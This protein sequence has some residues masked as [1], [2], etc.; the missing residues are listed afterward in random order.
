MS[1]RDERTRNVAEV[2][3]VDDIDTIV[4]RGIILMP[5]LFVDGRLRAE[6][7]I[8]CLEEIKEMITG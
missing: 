6:G 5:A 8:S 4:N 3:K 1:N 2:I 7:R